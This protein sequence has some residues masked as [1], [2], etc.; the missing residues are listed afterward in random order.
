M[1]PNTLIFTIKYFIYVQISQNWI[2]DHFINLIS[3]N[4][5]RITV[6]YVYYLIPFASRVWR[7]FEMSN[8]N[9]IDRRQLSSPEA[10]DID[11][12]GWASDLIVHGN[13]TR[14]SI[15]TRQVV[16]AVIGTIHKYKRFPLRRSYEQFDRDKRAM[17]KIFVSSRAFSFEL[18]KSRL[19]L[20]IN[21]YLGS[22]NFF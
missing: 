12:E 6:W 3:I 14:S 10:R 19:N 21:K 15:W 16:A 1:L 7:Y 11:R 20:H 2:I 18:R 17:S 5:Y 22:F 4:I 13:L 8:A 9:W